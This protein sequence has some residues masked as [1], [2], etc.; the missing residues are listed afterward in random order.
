MN[1]TRENSHMLLL[2]T[3]PTGIVTI[4]ISFSS[5]SDFG[6]FNGSCN[7]T[8]FTTSAVFLHIRR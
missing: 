3:A 8:C 6:T 1:V 5:S 7:C 2:T 4:S